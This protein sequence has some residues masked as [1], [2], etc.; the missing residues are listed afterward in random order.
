MGFLL[1]AS[2]GWAGL[3]WAKAGDACL[4]AGLSVSPCLK[5]Q[6]WQRVRRHVRDIM[7]RDAMQ[8][9]AM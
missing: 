2:L 5:K 4:P 1:L 3:D 6:G 9:D 8:C 7:Q